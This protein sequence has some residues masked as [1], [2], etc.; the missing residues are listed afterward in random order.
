LLRGIDGFLALAL[1]QSA[2]AFGAPAEA[3]ALAK[4]HHPRL[5]LG[6]ALRGRM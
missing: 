5:R 2:S 6:E 3:R 4:S 1:L